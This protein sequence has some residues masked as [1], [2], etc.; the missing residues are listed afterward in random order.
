[1]GADIFQFK[2]LQVEPEKGGRRRL[3]EHKG[4][5]DSRDMLYW[6]TRR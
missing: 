1:M 4:H 6:S 5:Q 3:T 2:N